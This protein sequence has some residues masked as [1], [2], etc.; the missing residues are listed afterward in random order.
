MLKPPALILKE[1]PG[2]AKHWKP[3]DIGYLLRLGLVQGV[4]QN[5][6]RGGSLI[7]EKDVLKVFRSRI[8]PMKV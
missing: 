1:N 2:I 3:N 4:K 6:G 8:E 5:G 7:E